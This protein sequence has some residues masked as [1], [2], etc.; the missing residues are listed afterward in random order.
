MNLA[1]CDLVRSDP[2][3]IQLDTTCS[4]VQKTQ[5]HTFAHT[6]MRTLALRAARLNKSYTTLQTRTQTDTTPKHLF[7]F[8]SFLTEEFVSH[9]EC[10]TDDRLTPHAVTL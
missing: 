4:F 2:G 5:T 7:F 8:F 9:G 10:D 1:G 3:E 6:Q